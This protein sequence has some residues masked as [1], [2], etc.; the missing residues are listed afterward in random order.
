MNALSMLRKATLR[1]S[2]LLSVVP[3]PVREEIGKG[4]E[5]EGDVRGRKWARVEAE[6]R[7]ENERKEND[8]KETE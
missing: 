4:R 7:K 8:R 1:P 5:E 6:E 3:V 2:D